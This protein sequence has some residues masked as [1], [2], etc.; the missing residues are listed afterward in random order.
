MTKGKGFAQAFKRDLDH[1]EDVLK[2]DMRIER[3]STVLMNPTRLQMYQYLCRYPCSYLSEIARSMKVSAPTVKWHLDKLCSGGL[4]Q[5]FRVAGKNVYYPTEMIGPSEIPIL[6]L[7]NRPQA[8]RIYLQINRE[9]GLTQK[10]LSQ[11]L[12][13]KHQVIIWHT[14]RLHELG[15][16][17]TV[18]DGR[19]IRYFPT[20]SLKKHMEEHMKRS[21][22]FRESLL[23]TFSYDGVSPRIVRSSPR[24]ITVQITMGTR[25]KSITLDTSPFTS[26]LKEPDF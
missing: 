5:T 19:F 17:S 7:M 11:H 23:R 15:L 22:T 21:K 18:T 16:I 20:D 2:E 4:I 10:E 25:R 9:P 12:D 13:V 1:E 26:V 3:E 6:A 8:R 14:N 24:T